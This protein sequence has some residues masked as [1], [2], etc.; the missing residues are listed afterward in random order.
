MS[1][2]AL[3]EHLSQ[4]MATFPDEGIVY[5]G[6]AVANA[7]GSLQRN[8]ANYIVFSP[9]PKSDVEQL[10]VELQRGVEF[11]LQF[12]YPPAWGESPR[13]PIPIAF[14][15]YGNHY[16]QNPGDLPAISWGVAS[17]PGQLTTV[18]RYGRGFY[19]EDS[20]FIAGSVEREGPIEE[21]RTGPIVAATLEVIQALEANTELPESEEI[22]GPRAL[23]RFGIG[24]KRKLSLAE[25]LGDRGR[26]DF[27]ARLGEFMAHKL[28]DSVQTTRL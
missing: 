1:N 25:Y 23:R 10:A 12:T 8:S 21:R 7:A 5:R 20:F 19:I 24:R 4:T 26:A 2:H 6:D 17:D 16:A 11:T 27:H 28:I 3:V 14:D 9:T 15:G 22:I 13:N 18:K